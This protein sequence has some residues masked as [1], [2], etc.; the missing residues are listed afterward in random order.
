[1]FEKSYMKN[2]I[3]YIYIYIYIYVK[4]KIKKNHMNHAYPFK[5]KHTNIYKKNHHKLIKI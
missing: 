5:N 1:M 3:K 4:N 2:L